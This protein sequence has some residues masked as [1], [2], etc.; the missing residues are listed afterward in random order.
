MNRLLYWFLGFAIL[1]ATGLLLQDSQPVAQGGVLQSGPVTPY[2]GPIWY[3]NG[4]I[5]DSGS[6]SGLGSNGPTAAGLS[7]QLLTVHGSGTPPYASV[8]SGPGGTNWCDYDAPVTNATG[9]HFLCVSP[10]A[11]GG[12]LINYGYGGGASPLPFYFIFNGTTYQFPFVTSGIVGPNSTVVGDLLCWN[13]TVGTLVSDCGAPLRGP[14]STTSGDLAC[15]NSSTGILLSDCGPQTTAF[16]IIASGTTDTATALD[17]TVA[18][19]SSTAAPKTQTLYAC[20]AGQK[21]KS[22]SIKDEVGT[23]ATYPITVTPNGSDTIDNAAFAYIFFNL[24]NMQV[25]CDGAANWIV[26]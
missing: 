9:Y 6:A 13:N 11:Q 10:N 24:Q 21:G 22:L 5:G 16:R 2:H 8:G 3:S 19:K 17:V 25:Q 15:W 23:A 18:W 4:I 26:K 7:E 12:G 20:G 14:G 1:V